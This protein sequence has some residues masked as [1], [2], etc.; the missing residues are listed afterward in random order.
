MARHQLSKPLRQFFK[1]MR[2]DFPDLDVTLT[3]SGHVRVRRP[4][5]EGMVIIAK[6]ASDH[7]ALR[8]AEAMI[9]RT[10]TSED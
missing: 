1:R 9:R 4:G 2:A 7:R 3:G 5:F 8:N 6:S 10:F